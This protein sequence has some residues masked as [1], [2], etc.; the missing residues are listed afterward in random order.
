[1]VAFP[2]TKR[3][4]DS[5]CSPAF[6]PTTATQPTPVPF[7]NCWKGYRPSIRASTLKRL[8][9]STHQIRWLTIESQTVVGEV[10]AAFGNPTEDLWI[11]TVFLDLDPLG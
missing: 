4:D 6:R 8:P 10:N 5:Q 2:P 7:V 11:E 1:M 3:V 9:I